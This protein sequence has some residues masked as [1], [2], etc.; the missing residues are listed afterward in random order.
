MVSAM[1]PGAAISCSSSRPSASY[2]DI[3]VAVN[4]AAAHAQIVSNSYGS[5]QQSRIGSL[6]GPYNHRA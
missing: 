3:G 6:A 1:C 2:A 4:F 5:A